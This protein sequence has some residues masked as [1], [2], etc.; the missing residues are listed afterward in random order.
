MGQVVLV[1]SV[2]DSQINYLMCALSLP[3]GFI[4]QV[5]KRRR[6]FMWAGNQENSTAQYLVAWKNVCT[7]KELGGLGTKDLGAQNICLL[8][9]LIHR[10]HTAGASAWACC[11][12]LNG[13]V[14]VVSMVLIWEVLRSLLPLYQ[15]ITS[16]CIGNGLNTSFWFDV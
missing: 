4:K 8:L 10:L 15:A 7:T 14:K 5:D 12:R 1:N 3:P 13:H 2:L 9:K 6:I 11:V 16:V